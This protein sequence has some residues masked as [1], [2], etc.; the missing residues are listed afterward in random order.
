MDKERII[1]R[2]ET[3]FDDYELCFLTEKTK[4]FETRERNLCGV[5]LKEETGVALRAIKDNRM[6]FSYT[7]DQS[8]GAAQALLDNAAMLMPI[9]EA[10]D[11]VEFPEVF[12]CYPSLDLY[13]HAGISADDEEKVSVLTEMEGA[14]L[15]YDKRI[16]ATRNCEIQEED[17][18]VEIVNS[19]GLKAGAVKTLYSL[20]ALC[21][22]RDQDEVSWY[23]WVWSHS[24]S[25]LNGKALGVNVAQKA[26]S[27]LRSEQIS[28]GI[29]DGILTSQASC[30]IL[31]LLSSSLLGESLYKDKT[32]LKGKNGEKCFSET[33]TIVD[34]GFVGMGSFPFDGEGVPSQENVIVKNG[35]FRDFLFDTYYGR[36]LRKASTGN[37]V[38]VG[39]KSPPHCGARGMF[40]KKGATDIYPY[41]TNGVIIEELMGTHTANPITGDFSLGAVGHLVESGVR[42]P[43]KGI[44]VSGNV[45]ELLCNV[46]EVGDDLKFYGDHGSPSLYIEGLKISGK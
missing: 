5:D 41:L 46:R 13:D 38:R 1:N 18:R 43:F 36:K 6:I 12:A 14:I 28:T 9:T 23:D 42:R 45:F 31:G 24:F 20:V 30:E 17:I 33:I 26:V 27:F 35:V 3:N 22:A 21:V 40:V 7:Y 32:K 4:R 29:Y 19:R 11:D 25:E 37:G 15:D 10:D 44:I 16:V 34:S 39:V 2:I 8:D